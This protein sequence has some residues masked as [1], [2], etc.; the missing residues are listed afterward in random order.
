MYDDDGNDAHNND[1]DDGDD[2]Y[3]YY[4]NDENDADDDNAHEYNDVDYTISGIKIVLECILK[5]SSLIIISIY[6]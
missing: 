6:L 4:C 3:Y 5:I 1:V 2:D